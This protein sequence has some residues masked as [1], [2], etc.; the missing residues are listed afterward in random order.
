M[1][2]EGGEKLDF[3]CHCGNASFTYTLPSKAF[4]LKASICHCEDCR[5]SSGQMFNTYAVIPIEQRPDFSHLTAYPS[6][7]NLTRFFCSKCGASV[8]NFEPHEWEFASGMFDRTAGLLNRLQMFVESTKDGGTSLWLPKDVYGRKN[9]G[10]DSEDMTDEE[11]VIFRRGRRQSM[12]DMLRGRCHC[13]AVA[14]YVPRPR[15]SLEEEEKR[16]GD[17]YVAGLCACDSCRLCTGFEFSAWTAVR[18]EDILTTEGRQFDVND[19]ALV[20]YTSSPGA[21]RSFCKTCGAKVLFRKDSRDPQIYDINVG[22]FRGSGAR[23]DDWL[24][25]EDTVYFKEDAKDPELEKNLK[26]TFIIATL[27][28]TIINCFGSAHGL[29]DRLQQKK[30]DTK[31]DAE[32]KKLQEEIK[33]KDQRVQEVSSQ[34]GDR[35]NG[36]RDPDRDNLERSLTR[37]GAAIQSAYNADYDRLGQRFAMGDII[38]QNELQ[39]QVIQLQQTVISILEEAVYSGRQPSRADMATLFKASE[40]AREGSIQALN[41]QYQRLLENNPKQ[42]ALSLPPAASVH[43]SIRALPAPTPSRH[44]SIRS[45]RTSSLAGDPTPLYCRYSVALQ[46]D[47]NRPLSSGF[48]PGGSCK[49]EACGIFI[50]IEPQRAWQIYK[51]DPNVRHGERTYHILNRFMIKCHRANGEFACVLCSRFRSVDTIWEDIRA[52]AK[53]VSRAHDPAEL[54]KEIDIKEVT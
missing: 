16:G 43:G 49:C 26:K 3:R 21:H 48:A 47:S 11:L 2:S 50:P 9:E 46:D 15:L 53:H 8:G 39:A 4:P 17:R 27:V 42:R 45:L 52:F 29:Y 35:R 1:A 36:G 54:N 44:G 18:P 28:S 51:E 14:F 5:H 24:M 30:T 40:A 41:H 34:N 31:Q 22:L 6:S 32:I 23:L 33:K 25:W 38:A 7:K 20:H 37:S 12:S 19:P 13:G 10:R